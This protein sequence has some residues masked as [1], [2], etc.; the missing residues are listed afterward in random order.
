MTRHLT[1][2]VLA[3]PE[4]EAMVTFAAGNSLGYESFEAFAVSDSPHRK[5]PA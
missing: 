2:Y 5:V 4:R 3:E 1:P